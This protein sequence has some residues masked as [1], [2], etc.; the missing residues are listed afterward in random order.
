VG[1]LRAG[2]GNAW[3][4]WALRAAMLAVVLLVVAALIG[5]GARR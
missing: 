1:K 2:R 5:R 4:V 3:I